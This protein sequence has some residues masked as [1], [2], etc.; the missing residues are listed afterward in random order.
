MRDKSALPL[1][2][3]RGRRPRRERYLGCGNQS[4]KVDQSR[5]VVEDDG[6]EPHGVALAR[7]SVQRST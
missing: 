4:S 6:D 3:L 5:L 7:V 2:G 1:L